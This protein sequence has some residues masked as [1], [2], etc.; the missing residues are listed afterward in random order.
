M[1]RLLIAVAATVLAAA[2]ARAQQPVLTALHPTSA[3][4]VT[5]TPGET[6]IQGVTLTALSAPLPNANVR[7]RDLRS[8]RVTDATTSDKDGRFTFLRV[9]P[10][11]YVVEL[12]GKDQMVLAASPVLN[13][14]AGELISTVL[15]LPLR[16]AASGFLSRGVPALVAVAA[17]SAAAGVLASTAPGQPVSPVR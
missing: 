17:A 9:E 11:S 14:N 6:A 5:P 4:V 16:M 1:H 2:P 7:L 13:L 3:V 10:G 15:K 12:I 8:G